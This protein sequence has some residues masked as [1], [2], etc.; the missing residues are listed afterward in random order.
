MAQQALYLEMVE[1]AK[2]FPD[3]DKP[4]QLAAVQ[5]FRLPYWDYYRPRDYATSFPGIVTHNGLTS[6]PYDFSA[7]QVLTL[8]KLIVVEPIVKRDSTIAKITKSIDNP[9]RS[10]YFPIAIDSTVKTVT[11]SDWNGLDERVRF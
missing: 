11:E 10:F 1:I 4:V 5:N 7:P 9:L 8:E 2:R 6:F 3:A